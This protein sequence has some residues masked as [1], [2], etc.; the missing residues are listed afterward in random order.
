MYMTKQTLLV[1]AVVVGALNLQPLAQAAES[2]APALPRAAAPPG[3]LQERIQ[4]GIR[5]LNLTIE[6]K[7]KLQAVIRA[8]LEKLRAFREDPSLSQEQKLAKLKALREEINAEAGKLLTPE[9]LKSWREKQGQATTPAPGP[10]TRIQETIKGLN[11]SEDQKAQLQ[12]LYEEQMAR[13]RELHQDKALSPTQKLDKLV[14][15]QNELAPKVKKVMSVE[16]FSKWEKEGNQW[17]E[18]LRKRI[19]GTKAGGVGPGPGK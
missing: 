17:T 1:L 12:P 14:A 8:H 2:N 19:D 7:D 11:L 4:S 6:Q 16:Q 3:P 13:L 15:M 18:Q 9:Q 5:D 10:M